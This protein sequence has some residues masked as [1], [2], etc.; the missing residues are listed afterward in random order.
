M[1]T[2]RFYLLDFDRYLVGS[3]SLECGSDAEALAK[4]SNLLKTFHAAVEVWE[5]IRK[6]GELSGDNAGLPA[7]RQAD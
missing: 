2:Y 7:R 5:G 3:A 1:A 6:V 4:G